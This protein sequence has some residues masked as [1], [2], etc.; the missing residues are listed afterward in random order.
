MSE[1]QL[2]RHID[3]TRAAVYRALL[4]PSA[5]QRWMVPDGMTSEIHAFDPVE[6][7]AFRISLT[8]DLPTDAGKTDA[9]TDRFHGTFA[10]LVPDAKVVQIVEFETDDPVLT[11][12]MTITYELSDAA[13]GTDVVGTHQNVPAGVSPAD[14]EIGWQM[15]MD[16]L[17]ALV[18]A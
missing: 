7:G 10:E 9:Q 17:A 8:Y 3:E 4:D 14:N 6:G 1:T 15:S 12:A 16:K 11:G 2:H 18:E 13:G 5:V